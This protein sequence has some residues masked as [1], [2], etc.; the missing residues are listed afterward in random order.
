MSFISKTHA[1]VCPGAGIIS[2]VEIDFDRLTSEQQ[3][4][5]D[6]IYSERLRDL[7]KSLGVDNDVVRRSARDIAKWECRR[8]IE[9][10]ERERQL[11]TSWKLW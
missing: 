6:G 10:Q 5:F 1:S 7:I 9:T 4:Y 3:K 2:S 8:K 11:K